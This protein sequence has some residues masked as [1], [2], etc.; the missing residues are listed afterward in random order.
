MV[1]P[2]RLLI[3]ASAIAI[4]APAA[5][6]AG[7]VRVGVDPRTELLG[8]VQ[9]LAD[10]YPVRTRL[11]FR[12]RAEVESSFAAF[13]EHPAVR[14]FLRRAENGFAF[15]A[16]VWVVLDASVPPALANGGRVPGPVVSRAGGPDTLSVWLGALRDFVSASAFEDFFRAHRGFY[17]NLSREA[18]RRFPRRGVPILE[19][20]LGV[21]QR[22]YHIVLAPLMHAGG[23]G[24][25]YR[26]AP[27]GA[28][29]VFYVAGPLGVADGR[30]DFGSDSTFVTIG[31]HEFSH[32]VINP[33]TEAHAAEVQ[34]RDS[35][36]EDVRESMAREGYRKWSQ[37]VDEHVIRAITVRLTARTYGEAAGERELEDQLRRGYRYLPA[38]VEALRNEYEPA[39]RRFPTIAAF[40]PRLL[41]AIG[42]GR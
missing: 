10:D 33:L 27:G 29:E 17:E 3:A 11:N 37:V 2:A 1:H 38:L 23:F 32:P 7:G 22:S 9:M 40:Y 14:M 16:P 34:A 26:S 31:W 39:R 36:L 18:K 41:E 15:D 25:D 13:R 42:R 8:V 24:V 4:A 28:S 30:P 19:S 12:Y 6:A 35:L 5:R 21:R 20:Y